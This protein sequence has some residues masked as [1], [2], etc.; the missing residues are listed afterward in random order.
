MISEKRQILNNTI[1]QSLVIRNVERLK[2]LPEPSF[3]RS[4]IRFIDMTTSGYVNGQINVIGAKSGVGKSLSM[5]SSALHMVN[6]GMKVLYFSLENIASIE[7]QRIKALM[8]Q[9]ELKNMDNFYLVSV[10]SVIHTDNEQSEGTQSILKLIDDSA[11]QV[12]CIFIDSIDYLTP[13]NGEAYKDSVQ[14][15]EAIFTLIGI[16]SRHNKPIVVSTQIK[17]DCAKLDITELNEYS[18]EFKNVTQQGALIAIFD[19]K[20][21]KVDGLFGCVVKNRVG[22]DS[23]TVYTVGSKLAKGAILDIERAME[24][25]GYEKNLEEE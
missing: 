18:L 14:S 24:M 12:D 16:A 22:Q 3:T 7:Y 15:R 5:L 2:T 9:Y 21:K 19:K 8:K 11:D 10:E 17:R 20:Y 6:D 1:S 4:Y 25:Y 13:R 23:G